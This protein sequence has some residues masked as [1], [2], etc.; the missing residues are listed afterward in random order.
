MSVEQIFANY[1]RNARYGVVETGNIAEFTDDFG[2]FLGTLSQQEYR[3]SDRELVK[4]TRIRLIGCSREYPFWDLSYA[5]G[6]LA[7]GTP[8]KVQLDQHRFGAYSYRRELVEL[9]KAAG[10]YGKGMGLL[11]NISTLRG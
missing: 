6:E 8:V 3:L 9:A 7:D 11:D 2:A 5:Y 4:I 10:R 1:D